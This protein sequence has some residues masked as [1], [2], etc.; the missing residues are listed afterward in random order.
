MKDILSLEDRTALVT[1]AGQGV[2]RQVALH[3]AAQSARAVIVNDFV[4][5]RA[6]AVVREVEELGCKG[7]ALVADVTDYAAVSQG[8]AAAVAT[9]GGLDILVNNAG[10]AGP[11]PEKATFA[12]FWESEP[13]DWAIWLGTNLHGVLNMTR[14]ALP[15]ILE[16]EHGSIVNIISDAGR[17]GEPH[18]PVYSAAKAGVAGFGRALAKA[19]GSQPCV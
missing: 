11:N 17:V 6:D 14:A 18:L 15:H 13:E 1:G 4:Q 8:V 16:S 12:P 3:L 10:N 9:V 19:V 5:E 2:G 7:V